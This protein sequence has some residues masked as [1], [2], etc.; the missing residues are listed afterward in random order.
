MRKL[1]SF[2]IKWSQKSNVKRNTLIHAPI[3]DT[4]FFQGQKL[5]I[6]YWTEESLSCTLPIGGSLLVIV[7]STFPLLIPCWETVPLLPVFGP[8]LNSLAGKWVWNRKKNCLCVFEN[9]FAKKNV[10]R[11][12]FEYYQTGCDFTNWDLCMHDKRC[13]LS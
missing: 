10:T 5:Y 3:A 1:W 8:K 11:K 4:C 6:R 13:Q 9:C 2:Q 7:S 12:L